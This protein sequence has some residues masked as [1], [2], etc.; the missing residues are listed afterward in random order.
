MKTIFFAPASFNLAEVTRLQ[1]IAREVRKIGHRAVFWGNG[2]Y[3]DLLQ[4]DDFEIV[5]CGE[6]DSFYQ[7]CGEKIYRESNKGSYAF[8]TLEEARFLTKSEINFLSKHHPNAVITGARFSLTISAKKARIPLVWETSVTSLDI[9]YRH[10]LGVFPEERENILTR[11]LPQKT[12]NALCNFFIPRL[13]IGINIAN[14]LCR[15]YGIPI[16]PTS[17][18]I[19]KGNSNL[20]T[21]I[22]ELVG[23]AE[24]DLPPDITFIGPLL[25]IL[26]I[27]LSKR[28][29]K[30]P[31][32][33]P[34]I[35]FAMGSSGDKEIMLDAIRGF[36]DTPYNVIVAITNI[37][38]DEDLRKISVPPNV[39]V[40]K[41]VP[42]EL[43]NEMA[44]IAVIHGGQG[45]VYTTSY[46]GTPFVG[47]PMHLEQLNNLTIFERQGCGIILKKVGL[48]FAHI[49]IAIKKILEN[50]YYKDNAVRVRTLVRKWDGG[51]IGAEKLIRW[52]E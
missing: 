18:S 31:R 24:E 30:I 49:Q 6:A 1:M 12:K 45:T 3:F 40:E 32:N 7:E 41:V 28:I 25:A 36:G 27:P 29:K 38:S 15:E 37:V 22:P 50:D 39:I 51:K 46:T 17:F 11:F 52:L 4:D 47:I 20:I 44:D 10:G 26:Q 33:R 8:F 9:F 42:A 23:I 21:D 19:F 2:G 43:V 13:R 16:I 14:T 35:Y 5:T 34:L 48:K